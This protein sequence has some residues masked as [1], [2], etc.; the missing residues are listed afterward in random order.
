ML[1]KDD[2]DRERWPSTFGPRFRF[3]SL[4]NGEG[5]G[6]GRRK[7]AEWSAAEA[8]RNKDGGEGESWLATVSKEMVRLSLADAGGGASVAS[9]VVGAGEASMEAGETGALREGGAKNPTLFGSTGEDRW[10]FFRAGPKRAGANLAAT[11]STPVA[12]S[13]QSQSP[14]PL[15]PTFLGSTSTGLS[16]AGVGADGKG[17]HGVAP[18]VSVT[19]PTPL[20]SPRESRIGTMSDSGSTGSNLNGRNSTKSHGKRK[21][22]DT[23]DE[24]PMDEHTIKPILNLRGGSRERTLPFLV[25][26]RI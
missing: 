2:H 4:R 19:A 20:T 3:G 26:E 18:H 22:V 9:V 23:E 25:D 7:S 16:A 21:I 5:E 13:Q 12:A 17:A 8:V 1:Q 10:R 24:K 6:T 11:A 14:A 15:E